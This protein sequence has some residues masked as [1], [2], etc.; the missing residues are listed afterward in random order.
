MQRHSFF[1]PLAI[2]LLSGLV[3]IG[4][5]VSSRAQ[6]DG[7]ITIGP[8]NMELVIPA[9][10]EKTVGLAVDYTRDFPDAKLPV[11]RLV[12]RLEDWT[13]GPAGDIKFAPISTMP[14]SAGNW[15]T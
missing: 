13:L 14:R 9:G 11:A 12:A 3:L 5:A 7:G 2:L 15:V 10:T 6:S 8:P 1:N 4:L